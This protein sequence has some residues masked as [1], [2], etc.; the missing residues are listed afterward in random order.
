MDGKISRVML[1]SIVIIN[2]MMYVSR[3]YFSIDRFQHELDILMCTIV[4]EGLEA[5]KNNG[6]SHYW[7]MRQL[8]IFFNR[9]IWKNN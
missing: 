3:S 7:A 6:L 1:Q 4:E 2:R 8:D 9:C 5:E